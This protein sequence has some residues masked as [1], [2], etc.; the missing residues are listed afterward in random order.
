MIF[1]GRRQEESCG[2]G[3]SD[4]RWKARVQNEDYWARSPGAPVKAIAAGEHVIQLKLDLGQSPRQAAQ[5][6]RRRLQESAPQELSDAGRALGPWGNAGDNM[7]K[8]MAPWAT[9]ASGEK[10]LSPNRPSGSRS[11]GA[12][13][14][15]IGSMGVPS[16]LS[17]PGG[18]S[19][20]LV[21]MR[22][23]ET[24]W[25]ARRQPPGG[26]SGGR[27]SRVMADIAEER[28]RRVAAELEASR[29]QLQHGL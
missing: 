5:E 24:P 16:I 18:A 14:R 9:S 17:Q 8:S 12:S 7:A 29:L 13:R 10:C 20:E 22:G 19:A 4:Q 11:S 15:S 27:A 25:S 1:T 21:Q 23:Y 28:N 6:R 2:S 3:E 26:A